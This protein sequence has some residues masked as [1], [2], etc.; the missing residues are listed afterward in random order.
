MRHGLSEY[1]YIYIYIYSARLVHSHVQRAV[2]AEREAA[3]A[4]VDLV[5]A[6]AEIE[7]DAVNWYLRQHPS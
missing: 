4:L 2:R 6:D 5:G 1:I 3:R 7:E